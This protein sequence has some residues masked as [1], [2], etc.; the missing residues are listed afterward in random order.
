MAK[1][2]LGTD[3]CQKG[4]CWGAGCKK[5]KGLSEEKK[6]NIDTDNIMVITRWRMG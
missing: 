5:M 2:M 3:S 1:M 4:G 6:K